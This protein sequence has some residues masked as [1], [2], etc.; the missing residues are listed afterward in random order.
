M[1]DQLL[2]HITSSHDMSEIN[3]IVVTGDYSPHDVWNTTKQSIVTDSRT[4]TTLLKNQFPQE[5]VV[6]VLGNHEGFPVNMFPPPEVEGDFSS[7]WLYQELYQQ[8]GHWI[9]N[10][11]VQTFKKAGYYSRELSSD[12]KLI[13]LNTNLCARLNFWQL[14]NPNDPGDQ[15]HFLAQE[16]SDSEKK[17]QWVHIIGH[18]APDDIQCTATWLHVYVGIL[19]RYEATIKGQFFGHTHFDEVRVYYDEKKAPVGVGYLGASVTPFEHVNPSYSVYT[20]DGDQGV[21]SDRETYYFNLTQANLDGRGDEEGR[22]EGGQI[23]Y[24]R[25]SAREDFGI[26]AQT[27]VEWDAFVQK[28][29]ADDEAFSSYYHHYHRFS[30]S[31][32]WASQ[33]SGSCKKKILDN[34]PVT[35]S[36]AS[37][38]F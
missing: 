8:W 5:L 23:S 31:K 27:P 16:L 11:G 25:I 17:G 34:I 21:V 2:K 18:I 29:R 30:D 36:L 35:D 4:V 24:V 37:S 7:S 1:I 6:P 28:M 9:P 13:T 38:H 3:Y 15:L 26:K 14:F 19:K 10:S 22:E 32:T 20:V 33:C 12:F